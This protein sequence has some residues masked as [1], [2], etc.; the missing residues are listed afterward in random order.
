[1]DDHTRLLSLVSA[2]TISNK[3]V[4]QDAFAL[5]DNPRVPMRAAVVADGLG[6]HYA[7]EVASD[8]AARAIADALHGAKTTEDIDLHS[9]FAAAARRIV[10]HV[11]A[12]ND[13]PADIDPANAFGTTAI[14]AVEL[15]T[16]FT[17]GYVG[18]G[19]ILHLRG[20][21]NRFPGSQ[22]LPWTALNY[23]NPH[24]IPQNGRNP[25][26]KL[27]SLQSSRV[28]STPTVLTISKDLHT[29]GDVVVCATDGIH[30]YDQTPMGRDDQ[31]RI[32]ISGEEALIRLYRTLGAFFNDEPSEERLD[33]CLVEYL[34]GL[35]RDGLVTDDCTLAVI[36]TE[37]TLR[38]QASVSERGEGIR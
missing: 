23:L 8:L 37:P 28:E 13:L 33:T 16:Q 34:K 4:N 29:F 19:S 6:S 30:S 24:T 27:L 5:V 35:Q 31:Q 11:A 3:Q 14:C 15:P 36:I 22:L 26:C 2:A 17:F 12:A 1:M 25:M 20:N 7:S 38:Y 9:A 18:N 21:F 32:W 10:N